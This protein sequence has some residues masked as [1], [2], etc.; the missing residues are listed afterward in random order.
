MPNR[1]EGLSTHRLE[2]LSDGIYAFAMTLLVLSF[3]V[4]KAIKGIENKQLTDFIFSQSD[5]FMN[6][7]L[8]FALL[9]VFWQINQQIFHHIKKTDSSHIWMNILTLMFV[10]FIPF[11]TSLISQ[12]P[13]KPAG[14]FFFALNIFLISFSAQI[15]WLYANSGK[16]LVAGYLKKEH[17]Q[18]SIRI[19]WVS[20]AVSATAMVFAFIEPGLCS[21]LY[22]LIPALVYLPWIRGNR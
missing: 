1:I 19:G 4:P 18:Q 11:S 16:R 6:Y 12:F 8:S 10:V 9:A 3:E 13:D 22:I 5:R 2:A 7:F 15:A 17:I 14:E 20:P 21:Y